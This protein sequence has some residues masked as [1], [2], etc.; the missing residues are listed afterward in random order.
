[1]G[2][3]VLNGASLDN[4]TTTK[5]IVM[6][7]GMGDSCCFPFSLGKV[8]KLFESQLTGV[9]V[10]SLRIGKN[11]M[12]D[13]ESGYFTHPDKQITNACEQIKSDPQLSNGFNAVGFS[14]GSQFL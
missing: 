3:T 8:K 9:Y 1:M 11:M 6:W 14:Q 10:K 7:H 13:Y 2:F 5:P 4:A 12:Q